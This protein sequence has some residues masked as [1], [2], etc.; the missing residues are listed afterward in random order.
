MKKNILSLMIIPLLFTYSSF[1]FAGEI[2]GIVYE[3]S[4]KTP[5]ESGTIVVKNAAFSKIFPIQLNGNYD[6]VGIPTGVYTVIANS[7]GH[8]DTAFKVNVCTDDIVALDFYMN[9][10]LTGI[11]VTDNSAKKTGGYQPLVDP[12]NPGLNPTYNASLIK[13]TGA[14]TVSEAV[15]LGPK[16]FVDESGEISISGGRPTATRTMI[17]GVYT[18]TE[19]PMNSIRYIKVYTGGIPAKYGDCS[20]GVIVIETKSFY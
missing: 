16:V 7:N 11:T 4:L 5:L 10:L 19:V 20:G 13:T 8:A 1:V 3:E 2:T 6:A 9:T 17:D 12:Y 14:R 18:N 15:A